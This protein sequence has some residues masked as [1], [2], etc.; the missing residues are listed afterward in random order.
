MKKA[1]FIGDGH[2]IARVYHG[3]TMASLRGELDFIADGTCLKKSD[4]DAVKEE[5]AAVEY[6]FSTWGMLALSAEEIREYLPACKAVF[7]AAGS[8]QY[9]ARPFLENGIAVHSAWAA[10][11]V[12]VA[13]YTFAQ[14]VLATKG[15]FHRLHKPG[16][17]YVWT[18]RNIY[19]D[20]PGNYDVT[21]GIIGAGMIGKMVIERLHRDLD[22]VRV[23]VFDPFL[24]DAAA[25]ELRVE[26][27][28]LE[29]LFAQSDVISVHCPLFPETEG[30]IDRN[31][32]GRMK[33][34]TFI[35]NTARGGC[36][37]EKDL[38][39]A[40]VG[41]FSSDWEGMPNALIEAMAI[42]LPIV[43]TDCPCGGPAALMTNEVDGILIPV[44]DTKAMENSINRL[45]E[46]RALAERFGAQAQKI[47]ER[48][49]VQAIYEQWRDFI[50]DRIQAWNH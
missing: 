48:V 33:K 4:F 37:V 3:E 22:G 20:F 11:G 25:A 42:G 44:G 23:L 12:P 31:A 38:A 45:I 6:V 34:T 5:L 49:N 46:D 47:V 36:I 17:G 18:N 39:D 14:I 24:S 21:V 13:E 41:A 35:I 16:S 30:M 1:A 32:I 7:Y 15:F 40:S 2:H 28:T 9:F 29:E 19:V 43:A 10:N 50:E 8:V 27:C 26:K